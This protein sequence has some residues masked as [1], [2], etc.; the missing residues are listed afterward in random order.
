[1]SYTKFN[2]LSNFIGNN[3]FFFDTETTGIPDNCLK[4]TP[5]EISYPDYKSD[6]YNNARIVQI[7]W[8]YLTNFD[9]NNISNNTISI[10]IKPNNFTINNSDIHGITTEY[11]TQNGLDI[12][13]A[14]YI[15]GE[16]ITKSDFIVGYNVYFDFYVLLSEFHKL[17]LNKYVDILL[18]MRDNK[19][20]YCIGELS[21]QYKKYSNNSMP[22]QLAIYKDIFNESLIGVHNA[23]NDI[24]A[25]IRLTHFFY[26][27]YVKN[28]YLL[29]HNNFWKNLQKDVEIDIK[30][31]IQNKKTIPTKKYISNKTVINK[32][33]VEKEIDNKLDELEKE[34]NNI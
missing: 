11:T 30:T 25:T 29:N 32:V 7:A 8:S 3:I 34:L 13:S 21:R 5:K 28:E 2:N 20:I 24:N 22:K 10:Y 19:R 16:I 6:N 1:M 12:K 14:L 9:Y 26:K 15:L 4:N 31:D 18:K 33:I 27:N 23:I 17:N